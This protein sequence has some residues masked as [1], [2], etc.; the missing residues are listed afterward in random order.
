MSC[1]RFCRIGTSS[2][3]TSALAPTASARRIRS[4]DSACLSA[5]SPYNWNQKTSGASAAS[6]SI[7]TLA[8]VEDT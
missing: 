4:K 3:S 1:T 7:G 2:V 5:G 8:T 6:R